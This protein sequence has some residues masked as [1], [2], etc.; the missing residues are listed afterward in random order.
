V[1]IGW[2]FSLLLQRFLSE[3]GIPV[4]TAVRVYR[5]YLQLEPT[6]T[7]E[8]IAY[9]KSKVCR[10]AVDGTVCSCGRYRSS[11]LLLH[12]QELVE[13]HAMWPAYL[14]AAAVLPELCAQCHALRS[15]SFVRVPH[16]A[17]AVELKN[18]NQPEYPH[19]LLLLLL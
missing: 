19:N 9:L 13:V 10:T 17:V 12:T 7:E 5:R 1:V 16:I 2:C 3:P 14:P 8:F 6:H 15:H 18:I 4:E 11:K